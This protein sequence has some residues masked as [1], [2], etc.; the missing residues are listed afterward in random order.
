MEPIAS[1]PPSFHN[2][3]IR[4]MQVHEY[5]ISYDNYGYSSGPKDIKPS[6][7]S[8]EESWRCMCVEVLATY[9]LLW[10]VH[11]W[12]YLPPITLNE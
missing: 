4:K 9:S 2:T 5:A 1:V 10:P 3:D 12:W 11:C 6:P 7:K 8:I